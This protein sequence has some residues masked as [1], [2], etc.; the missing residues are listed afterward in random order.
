[1]LNA[2]RH[3][4]LSCSIPL[5]KGIGKVHAP[6][7]HKQINGLH[8]AALQA[9]LLPGD[10]FMTRTDGELSNLFIPGFWSHGAVYAGGG[11]VVEAIGVGVVLKDLATFMMTKDYV[12]A[13]RPLF[14]SQAVMARAAA[15][16]TAQR[17]R[18][19]DYLFMGGNKAFYCFELTY[20]AYRE[21]SGLKAPWALRTT[22]GQETVVGA[23]I[24]NAKDKWQRLWDS[25]GFATV[26]DAGRFKL[27][28]VEAALAA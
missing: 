3:S 12:S 9:K 20:A 6:Y 8:V 21:G 15:W 27:V 26:L 1:M 14:A 19:Y 23:D 4:L 10:I 22:W 25:R 17:G 18:P 5:T 11:M 24:E 28:P 16:A 7:A 13:W 2:C